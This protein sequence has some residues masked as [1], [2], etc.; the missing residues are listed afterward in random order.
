VIKSIQ[1]PEK[2]PQRILLSVSSLSQETQYHP[3]TLYRMS[4]TGK[5]PRPVRIGG[6][7]R[8]Y[9]S[10]I[11]QWSGETVGEATPNGGILFSVGTVSRMLDCNQRTV[12]RLTKSGWMPQPL[13]IGNTV[14]WKA[15][16]IREWIANRCRNCQPAQL[17]A[18]HHARAA[19]KTTVAKRSANDK[20]PA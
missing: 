14:R 13:R 11:R 17:R 19:A 8:W 1:P 6:M 16:E 15:A 18:A 12:Y 10:E 7:L 9:E 4:D 5:L 3:R 20:R 2:E